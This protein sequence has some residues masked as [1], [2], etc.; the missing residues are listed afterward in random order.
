MKRIWIGVGLLVVM[1]LAG[2]LVGEFMENSHC[3]DAKVL[4]RAAA[5]AMAGD[6]ESARQL[7]GNAEA[8]WRKRWRLT[9]AVVDHGELETVDSLFSELKIYAETRDQ[10][11]YSA[12]CVSLASL[13]EALGKTHSFNW[14]NLL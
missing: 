3:P 7:S 14:W 11:H 5:K 6:W 13:L 12:T 8:G 10:P 4:E 9:A 2:I 1:L